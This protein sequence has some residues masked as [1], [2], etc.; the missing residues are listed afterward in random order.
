MAVFAV[1]GKKRGKL[2]HT[3]RVKRNIYGNKLKVHPCKYFT[4]H[5]VKKQ[6]KEHFFTDIPHGWHHLVQRLTALVHRLSINN[7]Q[8]KQNFY[9]FPNKTKSALI[10][11]ILTRSIL[12]I[13]AERVHNYAFKHC[14]EDDWHSIRKGFSERPVLNVHQIAPKLPLKFSCTRHDSLVS[15][16]GSSPT[17]PRMFR[18]GGAETPVCDRLCNLASLTPSCIFIQKN[19]RRA[20]F[21]F[22]KIG[23]K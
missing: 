20:T 6:K 19:P 21:P 16:S 3:F 12:H 13:Y 14:H 17:L 1:I 9:Q 23:I 22:D 4:I 15:T 2:L 18:I 7:L 11:A 5:R 10:Y 8:W